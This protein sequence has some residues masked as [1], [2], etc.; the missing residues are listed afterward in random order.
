[1][2]TIDCSQSLCA[3]ISKQDKLSHLA[4]LEFLFSESE[5]PATERVFTPDASSS[6]SDPTALAASAISDAI[7]QP[8]T[9]GSLISEIP[10]PLQET[11][12]DFGM[13]SLVG[14]VVPLNPAALP[15][16]PIA[17]ASRNLRLPSF[18]LLGIAAPHPDRIASI[19]YQATPFVGAGPLSHP[20]DPLHLLESPFRKEG[21]ERRVLTEASPLAPS[22]SLIQPLSESTASI[23][24][25]QL[26]SSHKSIQQYI[27]TTTPPDDEGKVDWGVTSNIKA[28]ALGSS[29]QGSASVSNPTSSHGEPSTA[30]TSIGTPGIQGPLQAAN[31]PNS[32]WLRDVIA[33]I[34]M[35]LQFC[36]EM[37]SSNKV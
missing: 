33:L 4:D 19:N 20:D 26:L 25:D 11:L 3:H 12:P 29:D 10:T 6:T 8:L 34:C 7:P 21:V 24:P 16:P 27:I 35:P 28:S 32:P 17:K 23:S 30:A 14:S 2:Q 1:M 9:T 5:S 36:T 18:D 22:A 37:G 31:P 13:S 15:T